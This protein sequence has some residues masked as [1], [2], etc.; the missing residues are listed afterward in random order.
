MFS[1]IT[2]VFS[3]I[4]NLDEYRFQ[5]CGSYG[6][7][8]AF[9]G[10]MDITIA[11]KDGTYEKNLLMELVKELERKRFITDHLTTPKAA[12]SRSSHSYMGV[13]QF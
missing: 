8:K 10:D 7:G 9:C 4:L 2:N 3:E 11:R 5:V 13:C 1:Y 6:R 12:D